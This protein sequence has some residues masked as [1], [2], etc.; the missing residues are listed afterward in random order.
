[1]QG[2]I[3]KNKAHELANKEIDDLRD[4]VLDMYSSLTLILSL[5]SDKQIR[6]ICL[7]SLGL[8]EEE[9]KEWLEQYEKLK[10]AS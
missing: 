6:A 7:E 10:G 3:M 8:D 4:T 5:T 9:R 1:M 2:I